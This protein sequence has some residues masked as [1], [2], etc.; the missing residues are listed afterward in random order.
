MSKPTGRRPG[1]PDTRDAILAAARETF[2]EKGYHGASIRAIAARAGVDGALVHH[3]FGTKDGLFIAAVDLP[4][5]PDTMLEALL[6]GDIDTLGER[7]IDTFLGLWEDPDTGPALEAMLRAAFNPQSAPMVR[8]FFEVGVL[9]RVVAT[10]VTVVEPD[11]LP[12]RA[13]L[14]ASQLLGLATARYI[15]KLDP[16]VHASRDELVDAY[17]P[18]IQRYLTGDIGPG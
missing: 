11:R 18:T 6:G 4:L 17:A 10:I 3:Y 8:E 14:V 15:L 2:A 13:G 9:G 5:Q 1:K 12:R 7:L 16:L